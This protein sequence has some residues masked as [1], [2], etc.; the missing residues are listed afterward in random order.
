MGER[1]DRDRPEGGPVPAGRLAV[2]SPGGT[3]LTSEGPYPWCVV[4]DP[5]FFWPATPGRAWHL[6]ATG[7]GP[8]Q[9]DAK[10]GPLFTVRN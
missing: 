9:G 5:S 6:P 3:V 1:A 7:G 10:I 4:L 8:I 2:L